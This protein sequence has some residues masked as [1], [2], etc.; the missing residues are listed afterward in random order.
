MLTKIINSFEEENLQTQ[1]SV[2]GYIIDLYRYSVYKT[3]VQKFIEVKVGCEIIRVNH[4]KEDFDIFTG[5]IEIFIH[6]K[7]LSKKLK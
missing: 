3:K 2:L 7:Q 6:I 4:D 5:I 1:Y